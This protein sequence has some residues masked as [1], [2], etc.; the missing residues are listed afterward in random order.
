[1]THKIFKNYSNFDRFQLFLYSYL[2]FPGLEYP[3][4]S[5]T[6]HITKRAS[7]NERKVD[8]VSKFGSVIKN[9]SI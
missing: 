3:Q 6:E 7:K 2:M 1:M 5:V 9:F 4:S 8:F